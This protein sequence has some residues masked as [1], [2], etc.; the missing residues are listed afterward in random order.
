M[1]QSLIWKTVVSAALLVA[2]LPLQAACKEKLAGVDQ[3]T[4]GPELDA[5]TRD[6][7]QL[8]RDQHAKYDDQR[9]PE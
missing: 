4:A 9:F 6:G 8:F 5:N 1:W 3:R 7:V 2:L